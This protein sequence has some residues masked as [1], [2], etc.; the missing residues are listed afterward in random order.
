M[1]IS[2]RRG[3]TARVHIEEKK[4]SDKEKK[5]TRRERQREE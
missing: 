1:I 3:G 4:K 2:C 5:G